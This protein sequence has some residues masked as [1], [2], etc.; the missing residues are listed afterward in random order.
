MMSK[1][2][3]D[4]IGFENCLHIKGDILVTFDNDSIYS[5]FN[6]HYH[7][8]PG[9]KTVT[10]TM[11]A[12][13]KTAGATFDNDSIYS[14][15]N[16]HYHHGPGGKTVTFTMNAPIKTAGAETFTAQT[17]G[18]EMNYLLRQHLE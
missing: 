1:F 2:C 16:K 10:F 18:T 3:L 9:G 15:F 13:I 11:N 12:P 8:G 17:A 6:K 14:D 7:H 5:D 4:N